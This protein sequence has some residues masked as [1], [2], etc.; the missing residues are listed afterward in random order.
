MEDP[1]Q[2]G[3]AASLANP[4][5]NITGLSL[6]SPDLQGK[7]LQLFKEALPNLARVAVL[8]DVAGRPQA[9]KILQMNSL[10]TAAR[11]LSI[12][13]GPVVDV[14]GPE[15][16]TAAF[17]AIT[18]E[19]AAGGVFVLG[20]TMLF[21][22]RAE[23]ARQALKKSIPMMCGLRAEAEAGCLMSYG[24]SL[25]EMFRRA[26][27]LVDKILKGATTAELPIEQPTT[28]EFVVNLKTANALRL[29]IP[30]S[31]LARADEVIE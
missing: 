18:K 24:G 11:A 7:R 3:F 17:A 16:I 28:F 6:Q 19:G 20:G 8:I 4:G 14:Q 31:V 1:V 12:G 2:Q 23:L 13:L 21:A 9:R 29:A 26:A 5:S 25:V 30:P 15:E 10:E 27:V 22:N